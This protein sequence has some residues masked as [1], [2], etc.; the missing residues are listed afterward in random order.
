MKIPKILIAAV[1]AMIIFLRCVFE[2][3][4]ELMIMVTVFNVVAALIVLLDIA[5]GVKEVIIQK[6]ETTC[7][8]PSIATREKKK[9]IKLFW[10]ILIIGVVLFI[11]LALKFCCSSL[12]NDILSMG[13]LGLSLLNDGIIQLCKNLYKV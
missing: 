10:G 2:K 9:F 7:A 8:A 6:I 1:F 5:G 4:S 12:G 11:G 3:S 13:S